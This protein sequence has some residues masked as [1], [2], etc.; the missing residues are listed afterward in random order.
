MTRSPNEIVS[1]DNVGEGNAWLEIKVQRK[2]AA[3]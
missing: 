2:E 1:I 3:R